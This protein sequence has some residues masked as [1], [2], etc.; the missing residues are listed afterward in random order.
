MSDGEKKWYD[1][2]KWYEEIDQ[3][4][5]G[6]ILPN[7]YNDQSRAQDYLNANP[8]EF[9]PVSGRMGGFG[10]FDPFSLGAGISGLTG[11][12]PGQMAHANDDGPGAFSQLGDAIAGG[13][14]KV[15]GAIKGG[16][17]AVGDFL[18]WDD[19]KPMERAWLLSQ[20][21]GTGLDIYGQHKAGQEED[22]EREQRQRSAEAI[23]PFIQSMMQ[24]TR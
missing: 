18:G 8:S 20:A 17:G 16:V 24:R 7:G 2:R 11:N 1:P 15:G 19:M 22:R 5:A 9:T 13:A 6:G 12:A 3:H 10:G 23:R 4:V 21:V 14:G